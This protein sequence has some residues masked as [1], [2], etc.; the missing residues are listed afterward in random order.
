[1][2]RH[3]KTR[4]GFFFDFINLELRTLSDQEKSEIAVNLAKHCE[5]RWERTEQVG[6]IDE[7]GYEPNA[8]DAG[9]YFIVPSPRQ[10]EAYQGYLRQFFLERIVASIRRVGRDDL[11][12]REYRIW[13]STRPLAFKIGSLMAPIMLE[14]NLMFREPSD[15]DSSKEPKMSWYGGLESDAPIQTILV[16]PRNAGG[17]VFKFLEAL[18]GIRLRDLG[19]CPECGKWFVRLTR[20][21]KRFCSH[22]CS[23]KSGSRKRYLLRKETDRKKHERE[24]AQGRDRAHKSYKRKMARV[25]GPKVKVSRKPRIKTPEE[26]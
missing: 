18:A 2:E 4:L 20:P 6:E 25:H 3:Q 22:L 7:T 26:A 10:M 17:V 1:M 5:W 23:S 14:V 12:E 21:D 9:K 19:E 15:P 8:M 11:W 13:G 16:P 24:L